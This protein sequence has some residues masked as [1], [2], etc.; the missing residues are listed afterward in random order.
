[1]GRSESS[2]PSLRLRAVRD[3]LRPAGRLP[4]LYA[5][6][7]HLDGRERN[8]QGIQLPFAVDGEAVDP[9][10]EFAYPLVS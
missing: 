4:R 5:E 2:P 8:V 1:M 10:V 7:H 3:A 6:E 9:I